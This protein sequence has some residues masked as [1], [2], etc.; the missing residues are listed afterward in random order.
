MRPVLFRIPYLG[1]PIFGYGLSLFVSFLVSIWFAAYLAKRRGIDPS[2]IVDLGLWMFLS[3]IVGGRLF[4]IIQFHDEIQ[5]FGDVFKI[6]EGGLVFY[7]GVLTG[8]VTF[9][10]FVRYYQLPLLEVLDVL[11]PPIALSSGIGRFGCL[12]NGCCWGKVTNVP[13]AIRFPAGSLPWQAQ[14]RDGLIDQTASWTLPVHP[15]QIYLVVA[16]LLICLV[17]LIWFKYRAGKGEVALVLMLGY[18]ITRFFIEYYRAD[19]PVVLASLTISQVIS[20]AM[21]PG[22]ALYAGWLWYYRSRLEQSR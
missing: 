18:A 19:V 17:T 3:G 5:S 20:L 8:L 14:V 6:W 11:S 7:G 9:V 13:W 1:L 4:Y 12:L 15:T 2:R 16:G 21:L 10:L 22:A